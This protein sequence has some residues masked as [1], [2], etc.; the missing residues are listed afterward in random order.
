MRK[1]V[2]DTNSLISAIGWD[3]PPHR[4]LDACLKGELELFVSPAI[5]QELT[6]VLTRP[7]LSVVAAHPDLPIVLSWL[8]DPVRLVVPKARLDV[9]KVDPDDNRIIECAVEAGA[10]AVIT[11]DDHLLGLGDYRGIAFLRSHEACARWG[12]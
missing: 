4:V 6:D 8:H 3:G 2:M 5:L 7:K 11:G 12:I 10:E 1:I 9:V